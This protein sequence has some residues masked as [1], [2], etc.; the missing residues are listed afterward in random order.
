MKKT[1]LAIL[2]IA[3]VFAS[4]AS[5]GATTF[6]VGPPVRGGEIVAPVAVPESGTTLAMLA[7]GIIALAAVR[8]KL[9]K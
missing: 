4:V 3:A 8:R 6:I 9:A 2:T 7:V 5:A 1:H